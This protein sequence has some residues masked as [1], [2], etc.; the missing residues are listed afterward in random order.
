MARLS[1]TPV[2]LVLGTL[3]ATAHAHAGMVADKSGNVGYDT[4]AECDAAVQAGTARFYVP[5]TRKAPLR[6]KGEVS[7]GTMRLS[8]LGP[9]FALG[10][11]DEGVG[12]KNGRNGVAR[13]LQGKFVP[14]SPDMPLN[15]Y[16]DRTGK[17]VRVSMAQ[18]DNRFAGSFPRAVP[19][20]VAAAP[21][22]VAAPVAAPA[23][24]PAAAPAAAPVAAAPKA[25]AQPVSAAA[26]ASRLTPYLFGTI[27]QNADSVNYSA[28]VNPAYSVGDSDR[29]AG[30]LIG[31]GLQINDWLGAEIFYTSGKRH[32]YAA[33]NAYVN[34]YV[35]RVYGLRATVGTSLGESARVFFKAGLAHVSHRNSSGLSTH[36]N[37]TRGVDRYSDSQIRPTLGLGV[38]Y[39]LSENVLLR[40]DLDHVRLRSG[41]N[42]RW[43]HFDHV[44]V[45]VQY[46][47]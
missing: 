31:A 5:T 24:V 6:R 1:L 17:T 19:K 42:P 23:P 7:V 12:R 25:S 30:A 32:Q 41:D 3:F 46:N 27:G 45:G 37:Q 16:K 38:T 28:P 14:F 44:G 21:A 40:A 35:S 34:E 13:E 39:A 15:A 47:F 4:A 22:P 10:A 9:E 18:C 2:A 8:D 33:V 29:K 43:G 20:P 36:W 11:C 26:P